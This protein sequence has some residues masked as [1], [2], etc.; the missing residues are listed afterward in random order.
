MTG[1]HPSPRAVLC[2]PGHTFPS[3]DLL[4]PTFPSPNTL[5]LGVE[6]ERASSLGFNLTVQ[7]AGPV[8]LEK[9]LCSLRVG[10]LPLSPDQG[11]IPVD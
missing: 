6:Q 4:L 7:P 1:P 2:Y 8:T 9:S 3:W 10:L 11:G 5:G